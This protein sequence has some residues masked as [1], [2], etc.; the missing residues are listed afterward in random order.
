MFDPT[1]VA[2]A[3]GTA[4]EKGPLASLRAV[5]Q[6]QR[7]RWQQGERVPVEAYLAR[8]A[9]L[10]EDDEAQLD[11]I[12][13]EILLRDQ[14]SEPGPGLQEYLERFPHL[15]Q[16]LRAQFAVEHAL[17][18]DLAG[19]D[20]VTQRMGSGDSAP[21][22]KAPGLALPQIPGYQVVSLLG[23]GAMGVV[24][25]AMD[26]R[27]GRTVALKMVLMGGLAESADLVRF[28]HEAEATA[29]LRHPNLVQVFAI[30]S[31]K[32]LPYFTMEYVEGGTLAER[33]KGRPLPPREAASLLVPVAAAVQHA[34]QRGIVHRDLKPANILLTADG[35]P[36]IADFGLA[37]QLAAGSW[38]TQTGQL[39]GTPCYM[40]PE[41]ASSHEDCIGSAVD[42][43]ALGAILYQ[44]LTGRPPFVAPTPLETLDQVRG[45]E[46]VPPARLQPRV[47]RDLETICLKCLQKT[48]ALR[49]ASVAELRDD[50]QRFLDG[51]PVRARR[52]GAA[53]RVWHWSR[54]NRAWAAMLALTAG[55]LLVIA[56]GTAI[57]SARLSL[58]HRHTDELRQRA[59]RAERAERAAIKRLWEAS[60]WRP[61]RAMNSHGH[62]HPISRTD[63][64]HLP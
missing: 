61:K 38:L 31:H 12:Y 8:A 23:R 41:Q 50:L 1:V 18:H 25:Q 62:A 10:L 42:V 48:P 55:L 17:G 57:F 40:A 35:T 36:K 43:F 59:E 64:G 3:S 47:P 19:L 39:L 5:L 14:A 60:R 28:I 4:P 53:G 21:G 26:L 22:A 54:R 16:P 46:P 20:P 63:P 52:L 51:Q 56:A 6:D 29:R 9:W 34:H 58:A 45:R 37:R 7:E 13:Q 33:L 30:G 49:Y 11:L 32:Q 2:S 15:A 27:L 24:Y 44:L